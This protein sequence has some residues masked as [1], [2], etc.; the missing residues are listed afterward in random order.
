M[1]RGGQG[2]G[3]P[4]ALEKLEAVCKKEENSKMPVIR[5]QKVEPTRVEA[6]PRDPQEP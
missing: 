6:T 2:Q 5:I 4:D 1:T 3:E